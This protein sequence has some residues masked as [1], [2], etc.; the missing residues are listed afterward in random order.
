MHLPWPSVALQ[1]CES[2]QSGPD[3][4]RLKVTTEVVSQRMR[5]RRL[6]HDLAQGATHGVDERQLALHHVS[7]MKLER[8]VALVTGG[9]RGIGKGIARALAEDGASLAVNWTKDEDAA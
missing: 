3:S 5:P 9:G 1:H 6:A 7:P 2:D 8:R 4:D